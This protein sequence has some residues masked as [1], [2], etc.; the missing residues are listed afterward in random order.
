MDYNANEEIRL[1]KEIMYSL[2][3]SINNYVN[4]LYRP[5]TAYKEYLFHA[6]NK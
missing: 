5:K 4:S 1:D 3:V 2:I 6:L